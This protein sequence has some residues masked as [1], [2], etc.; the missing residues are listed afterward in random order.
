MKELCRRNRIE[1]E[2]IQLFTF[3]IIIKSIH[4]CGT[5][6][7][8]TYMKL[9]IKLFFFSIIIFTSCNKQK[10]ERS[11]DIF[12]P[13]KSDKE[14]KA[15]SFIDDFKIIQLSTN[16]DNLIFQISKIQ[17]LNDKIYIHDLPGN[18]VLIFNDDGAFNNKL[19]RKGAGPG[20]YMQ[21][22][23]FYIDGDNLL[24]LD[25]TQQAILR[26]DED[27]EFINKIYFKSHGGKLIA[28]N[29]SFLIY[30]EPSGKEPDFQFTL[31][32]YKGDPIKQLLPRNSTNHKYIWAQVNVF[33]LNNDE[34]YFSPRYSDTIFSFTT[35]NS[36]S[37]EFIVDF[38]EHKF[39]AAENINSYDISDVDFP[40]LVKRNFYVSNKY[41]VFDYIWN[42]KRYF[43]IHNKENNTNNTG[44][45]Q[46]DLIHDFRFFP[47]WGND[48]YLIEELGSELLIEH[49]GSSPQF[50]EFTNISE[51]DN[52]FIIIYRL[53]E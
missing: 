8:N 50:S 4:L 25:Y 48:N 2:S 40:Y 16:D 26:Y 6:K 7:F 11:N 45:V 12:V 29:N 51:D 37:P 19:N 21:I 33:A 10:D 18:C 9:L 3:N 30:N 53:K 13:F 43:C 1:T 32:S 31:L 46:N 47:R 41:L 36:I 44:V 34:K 28:Q 15:S 24:I 5:F 14:I 17:Y 38:E 35:D 49:F 52:P 27:L 23:D 39:P 20:E 42:T 22:F